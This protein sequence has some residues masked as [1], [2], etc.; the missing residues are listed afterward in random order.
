MHS[1]GKIMMV[2]EGI[3]M[4]HTCPEKH[5]KGLQ[6]IVKMASRCFD[7]VVGRTQRISHGYLSFGSPPR[8]TDCR[9]K[10]RMLAVRDLQD[11]AIH[12]LLTLNKMI[13]HFC[14]LYNFLFDCIAVRIH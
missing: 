9:E 14:F 3:E 11:Y 4:R 8:S 5:Q 2:S 13:S 6:Y 7:N 12:P 1:Q 10:R